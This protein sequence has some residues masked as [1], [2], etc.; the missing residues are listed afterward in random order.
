[1][2]NYVAMV[3]GTDRGRRRHLRLPLR[4]R[5]RVRLES[6]REFAALS[7]GNVSEGG[8][9][10]Q[11]EEEAQVGQRV[12]IEVSD[13]Q[14]RAMVLPGEVVHLS[15]EDGSSGIG[16]R[17]LEL[18]AAEQEIV[19]LLMG[20]ARRV[21]EGSQKVPLLCREQPERL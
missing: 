2:L 10:V 16:V 19:D 5:V 9:F 12:S 20:E 11:M 4:K 15:R 1:S 8:V 17:F 18:S 21:A 7:T 6:W 3:G 14:G 13:T